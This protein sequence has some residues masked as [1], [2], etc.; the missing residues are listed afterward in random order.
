[1]L[2][3]QELMFTVG[4]RSFTPWGRWQR[5]DLRIRRVIRRGAAGPGARARDSV[6]V[7]TNH[8]FPVG[9]E[10]A[11]ERRRW[12]RTLLLQLLVMM[13]TDPLYRGP[14]LLFQQ[15]VGAEVRGLVHR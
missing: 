3:Q 15:R 5:P 6:Y 8:T 11:Q 7:S 10:L 2:R 12:K 14:L 13:R 1:M 9:V 4:R